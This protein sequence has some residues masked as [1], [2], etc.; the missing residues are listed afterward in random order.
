MSQPSGV[1]ASCL[2]SPGA[3]VSSAR[4]QCLLP[5]LILSSPTIS[6]SCSLAQAGGGV[7][8]TDP[9]QVGKLEKEEELLLEV[10]PGACP[11]LDTASPETLRGEFMKFPFRC[12][13]D[14]DP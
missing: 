14:P 4:G 8:V 6:A 13:M 9:V 10:V 12:P 2:A 1:P 7:L 5:R 11:S 3:Q